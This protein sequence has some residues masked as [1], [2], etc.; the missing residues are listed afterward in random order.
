AYDAFSQVLKIAPD[1]VLARNNLALVLE[2]EERLDEACEELKKV[3]QSAPDYGEAW[4]NLCKIAEAAG[5]YELS[6]M[7]GRK[8]VSLM[9]GEPKAWLGFGVALNRAGR[10]EEALLAYQNGLKLKSDWPE[11]WDNLGQTYQALG[12]LDEAQRAYRAAIEA[13]GQVIEG[14]G[15]RRIDEK[16]YGGRHW[17]LALLELLKG[18]LING[19]SRYRARFED[20]GGLERPHFPVPVWQGEDL[21]NKTLL[22]MDE[23]GMGDCLM[24]LRYLPL[25]K[26]RGARIKLLIQKPLIPLLQGWNGAD[27]LIQRGQL[28]RGFGMYA[29]IFD[30]PY[31]FSTTLETIPTKPYLPVPPVCDE[32]RLDLA[33]GKKHI[34]VVWGGAPKHKQDA[35]R[36][37]PLSVF[38]ELF[39][40]PDTQFFSLNR[41]K[42]EGDDVLLASLPIVDLA[43]TLQ[44]FGQVAQYM[45]QMDLIISCDTA[46]AHLAGA[47][48]LPV[49]TLLPFAPDW[50]W[51]TEREDSP[52]YPSMRLFRQKTAGD[53]AEVIERVEAAL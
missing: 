11:V 26:A 22:V 10:D 2:H 28:V 33:P 19:F 41:D 16:E 1:H 3:V 13:D 46:T 47:M 37:L 25:M 50:R 51:L 30:L 49:W 52:W 43:P 35:K 14:D 36:S 7:A 12:R 24:M 21:E 48:G 38:S 15:Q 39:Q 31:A 34:A 45:A 23:Q 4:L 32:C 5:Q 8:L 44:D 20:V 53:W 27:E 29:S 40:I 42:R 9:P 6:L 17:H 18:D